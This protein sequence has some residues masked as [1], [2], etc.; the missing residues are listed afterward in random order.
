MKIYVCVI[1]IL[2][3]SSCFSERYRTDRRNRLTEKQKVQNDFHAN[4]AVELTQENIENRDVNKKA[5]R[6]RNTVIQEQL[7]ELNAKESKVKP[8][9]KHS[10]N[11]KFY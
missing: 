7:N 4:Q 10:G 3:C 9:K 2:L 1:S 6:K 8:A 5:A 11:F